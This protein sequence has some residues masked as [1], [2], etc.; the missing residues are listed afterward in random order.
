MAK[1]SNYD[2]IQSLVPVMCKQEAIWCLKEAEEFLHALLKTALR[3][4]NISG[5]LI[6][7][8]LFN[9]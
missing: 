2:W 8:Y 1:P 9:F 5:I 7:E 6:I 4:P 3:N